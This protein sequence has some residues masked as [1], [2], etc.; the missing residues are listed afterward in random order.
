MSVAIV[1]FITLLAGMES[2]RAPDRFGRWAVIGVWVAFIC[3]VS[4]IGGFCL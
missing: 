1:F 3:A 2:E 4:E